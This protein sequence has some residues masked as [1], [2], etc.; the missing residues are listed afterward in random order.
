MRVKTNHNLRYDET[1]FNQYN[2]YLLP[3]SVKSVRV[4]HFELKEVPLYFLPGQ[5]LLQHCLLQC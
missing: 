5:L 1:Y 4:T 3:F 2:S